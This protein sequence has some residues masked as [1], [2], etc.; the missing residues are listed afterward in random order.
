M[1]PCQKGSRIVSTVLLGQKRGSLRYFTGKMGDSSHYP[2]RDSHIMSIRGPWEGMWEV[3]EEN[4]GKGGQGTTHIVKKCTPEYDKA[5]LKVLRNNKSVQARGR[6]HREVASLETLAV[7]KGR[8]PGVLDQNTDKFED[9]SVRLYVVMDFIEG[10]TLKSV[11]EKD[12][13]LS[14]DEAV[15]VV[16]DI[17]DTVEVGH[18]NNVLHRDLKPENLIVDDRDRTRVTILDYGLSFNAAEDEGLTQ[19]NETFAN[20]FLDLPETNVPDGDHRDPRSDI[21]AV[22]AILYYCLTSHKAVHLRDANNQPPH[23]RPNA[24]VRDTLVND[25]RAVRLESVLDRAFALEI[26]DRFTTVDELRSQLQYVTDAEEAPPRDPAE[27]IKGA[28]ARLIKEDRKVLLAHFRETADRIVGEL[29]N[30]VTALAKRTQ[31]DHFPVTIKNVS[32]VSPSTGTE[33]VR[34][35]MVIVAVKHHPIARKIMYQFA[36]RTS[37]C[38]VFRSNETVSEERKTQPTESYTEITSFERN[39]DPDIEL[40]KADIDEQIGH[41][42]NTI[43]ETLTGRPLTG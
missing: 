26:A 35:F 22:C 31:N 34:G 6:M 27:I 39:K 20:K 14:L 19:T 18:Q 7:A 42:V 23:R 25:A 24:S 33:S 43:L 16:L 9:L 10:R 36:A 13:P 37:R 40:I 12:G 17:C 28:T 8:V 38:C 11:I 15:A 21:T 2:P 29:S 4:F 3:I 5:V 1:P 30:H 32:G 41:C